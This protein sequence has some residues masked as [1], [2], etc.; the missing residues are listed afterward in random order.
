MEGEL[1]AREAALEKLEIT[2]AE[3][4]TREQS[5]QARVDALSAVTPEAARL[6]AE[7]TEPAAKESRRRDYALFLGGVAASL[8]VSLVV[9]GL[10]YALAS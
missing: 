9:G 7:L 6:F 5:M 10:F 3:L 1:A 8:V 4:G 2:L